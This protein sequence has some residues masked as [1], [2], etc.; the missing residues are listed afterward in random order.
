MYELKLVPFEAEAF[1]GGFLSASPTSGGAFI[2]RSRFAR[3]PP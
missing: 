3:C 1:F 2:K